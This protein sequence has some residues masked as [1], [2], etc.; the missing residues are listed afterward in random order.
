MYYFYGIPIAD[1]PSN[2]DLDFFLKDSNKLI[3]ISTAGMDLND[4]LKQNLLNLRSNFSTVLAYR[5]RFTIENNPEIS[6]DNLLDLESYLSFFRLIAK[7]GFYSYDKYD[8]DN[9]EDNRLQLICRPF[10]DRNILIKN[11]PFIT[12]SNEKRFINYDLDLIEAKKDFPETSLPFDLN[13][14][15]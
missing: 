3:H 14:F 4:T 2:Y 13:E 15:I 9:K 7:R 8:I 5:R 11:T 12:D 6:R 1:N 10:Y